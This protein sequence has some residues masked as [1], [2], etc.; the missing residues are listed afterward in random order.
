DAGYPAE[1]LRLMVEDSGMGVLVAGAGGA[2]WAAGAGRLRRVL[3]I[4]EALA[5][6][7][8]EEEEV[9]EEVSGEDVA[10]VIYT[11]GSTG[12]P[13]G[14][15]IPHKAVV[16]FL[17]S[18]AQSPGLC[19]DDVLLAVTSLSFDIA[20][21]ELYLPLMVG[22]SAVIVSRE[23]ASDGRLL[24]ESIRQSA[25]TVMQ[26]T[27]S[28]WRL[29]ADSGWKG[30]VPLKMLCGGEALPPELAAR[31]LEWQ[32]PVYNLYGP[33]ETTI[34]STLS[35]LTPEGP[36]SLGHPIANTQ[37]Y[38]LDSRLNLAPTGARGELYIA[39]AGLAHGY[40]N[41][42]G[43]TAGRF[44]PNP[45]A[46]EPGARMY[47]TGDV[48]R[49]R[50]D[51]S[52]EFLGRVDHQ[53][54]LRGYRIEIGEVEHVLSAHPA[55]AQAVVT[56]REDIPGNTQLVA[57]VVPASD[58]EAAEAEPDRLARQAAQT[59]QWRMVW[60]KIYEDFSPE[61]DTEFNI[62]GWRSSYTSLPI[63]AHEMRLWRDHTLSRLRS[64]SPS[65]VL[66]LGC[67]TGLLLLPLARE[68][69]HYL[70]LD[71]SPSS[72][73]FLSR[74]V[75]RD[76]ALAARVRLLRRH[77]HQLDGIEEGSADLAVI[78]SVVQY[79]PSLDYLLRVLDALLPKLGR[80]GRLFLGDLR[81]L[82]LLSAFHASVEAGRAA[83]SLPLPELR[84]RVERAARSESE[85]L[86][87]PRL[88]AA[89]RARYPR[90]AAVSVLPKRGGYDNELSRFRYDVVLRLDEAPPEREPEWERWGE[91]GTTP[92]EAAAR[93]GRGGEEAVC[94]RGVGNARVSEA[95]AAGRLLRELGEEA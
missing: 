48:A 24:S 19:E 6:S 30:E 62:A 73:D 81:S 14:V 23:A 92:E 7:G 15:Q 39:G 80:G 42:P 87:D 46:D 40:L 5:D 65:R 26:A 9:G 57:Y 1:R 74:A 52:L 36:V 78:N 50:E 67:G 88:F 38:L 28:T 3:D 45:F 56:A 59:D 94:V 95:V 2:R 69:S 70:G 8:E 75:R 16:N 32:G 60:D 89:L 22:A 83:A 82:P 33:T 13:K 86:L 20:G 71:F 68:V 35:R 47:R 55:V 10:Y 91:P 85:L 43:L 90:L 76:P 12:R 72:L 84:G 41:R 29:L 53:I 66:E 18:M 11:S 77:A 51:G 31:M 79:F 63:P 21:L 37:C 64:L 54:K 27:P 93:V 61:E 4:E 58:R 49:Y 17:R 44:V 25:A 34:W